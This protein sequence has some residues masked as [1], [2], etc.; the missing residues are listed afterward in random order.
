MGENVRMDIIW[1]LTN[2]WAV[3]FVLFIM[4]YFGYFLLV[5]VL[6]KLKGEKTEK[7]DDFTPF[8]SILIPCHNAGSVIDLKLKN[9]LEIDYP[10][11]KFEI[12]VVDDGSTDNTYVKLSE[13][14]DRKKVKLIRQNQRL[15]KA[16]AI[17]RGLKECSDDII[18][19]TDDDVTIEKNAVQELV[20]NF[21]DPKVGAVV[22]SLK[23]ASG[24]SRIS[25]MNA[26]FFEFFRQ[27]PRILESTLDSASFWSGALCAFRKSLLEKINENMINDDRYILLKIRSKGHRAICDPAS[28]AYEREVENIRDQLVQ[29]RRRTAGVIQGTLKFKHMLLNPKYGWFGMLIF[30][31]HFLQI[32]LLPILLL[33]IQF[34][35][36]AVIL[37]LLSSVEIFWFAIGALI[38]ILLSLLKSGQKILYLIFYGVIVQIAILAGAI[39]YITKKYTVLWVRVS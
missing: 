2:I 1:I 7:V 12:I 19:L 28:H 25:K 26:L 20:K 4:I 13:Y 24:K 38:L 21:G 18:V 10:K 11:D 30:P 16:S 32:I 37:V 6:A 14:V 39:D 22:S 9:T 23:V 34:L 35:S 3:S 15:G 8:I 33:I 31:A 27:K 5:F 36:P 29:K 17:N